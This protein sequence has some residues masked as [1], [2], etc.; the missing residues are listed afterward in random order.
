M[1][2]FYRIRKRDEPAIPGTRN[3]QL[4]MDGH[5]ETNISYEL[6]H[7]PIETTTNKWMFEVP[8]NY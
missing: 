7:H 2:I 5:G 3:N 1:F 8:G 6:I 4:K